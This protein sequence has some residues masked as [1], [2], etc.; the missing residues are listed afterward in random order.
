MIDDKPA[1]RDW[2]TAKNT[3]SVGDRAGMAERT[4]TSA[5]QSKEDFAEAIEYRMQHFAIAQEVGDPAGE[6]GAEGNLG[7]ACESLGTFPRR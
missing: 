2:R 6:G 5:Y 7:I 3:V 1:R 4:G